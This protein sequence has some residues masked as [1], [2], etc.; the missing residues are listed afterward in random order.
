MVKKRE[1]MDFI[2]PANKK[3]TINICRLKKKLTMTKVA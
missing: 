2:P 3:L 1:V